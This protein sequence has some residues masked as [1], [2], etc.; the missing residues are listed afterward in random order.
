MSTRF[1]GQYLLE[2]GV[3]NREQLLAAVAIQHSTNIKLG[4][5]AIDAGFMDADAVERINMLQRK[6][7]KRFGELAVSECLLTEDQLSTLLSSQMKERLML[8]EALVKNGAVTSEVL[9]KQLEAFKSEIKGIPGTLSELFYQLPNSESLEIFTDVTCKMFLR[10]LHL[11]VKPAT[12]STDTGAVSAC[13]YTIY[14]TFR[15][16]INA[17]LCLNVSSSVLTMAAGKLMGRRVATIDDDTLDGAM[18]FLNI[19]SGNICAKLSSL[20]KKVEIDPPLISNSSKEGFD[21]EAAAKGKRFTVVPLFEPDEKI[22]LCVI[23]AM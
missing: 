15:G 10:L 5:R 8:G 17:T 12:C 21:F 18:E 23:D 20:G 4:T 9:G 3:I 13:D 7:D 11:F 1:F 6:V 2:N 22:E 16:D 19:T 14:Q